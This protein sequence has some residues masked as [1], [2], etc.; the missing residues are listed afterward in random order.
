MIKRRRDDLT[1]HL[2]GLVHARVLF[3]A[4]GATPENMDTLEH[5][6]RLERDCR[7]GS[8]PD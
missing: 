3:E 2:T 4:R 6:S 8:G 1:S 7:S 5:A